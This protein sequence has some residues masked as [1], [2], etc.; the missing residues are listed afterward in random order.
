MNKMVVKESIKNA[1]GE[2]QQTESNK[3]L[4]N[5]EARQRLL[6]S[7]SINIVNMVNYIAF[8]QGKIIYFIFLKNRQ[9]TGL[10][11]TY[12]RMSLMSTVPEN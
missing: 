7:Y 10:W 5:Q 2:R 1:L 3:G 11:Y 9:V 8:F 6:Y 12:S 4:P